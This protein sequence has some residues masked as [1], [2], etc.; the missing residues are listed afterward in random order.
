M[1]HRII[2]SA[3]AFLLLLAFFMSSCNSTTPSSSITQDSTTNASRVAKA[4]D[5]T[6]SVIRL[7]LS[8]SE[9]KAVKKSLL[10]TTITKATKAGTAMATMRLLDEDCSANCMTDACIQKV[11][12]AHEIKKGSF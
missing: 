3:S 11:I 2:T 5:S 8:D 12:T 4:R 9:I 10:D 1:T 6:F 7:T